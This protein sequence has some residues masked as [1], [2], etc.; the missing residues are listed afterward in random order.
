M[1]TDDNNERKRDKFSRH[2]DGSDD[3]A[4]EKDDTDKKRKASKDSNGD[5]GDVIKGEKPSEDQ[6][7]EKRVL[8]LSQSINQNQYVNL[9]KL[10]F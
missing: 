2:K 3:E 10:I 5:S 6:V 4:S 8:K 7:C 9:F 1:D